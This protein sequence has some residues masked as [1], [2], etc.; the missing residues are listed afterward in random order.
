M[1]TTLADLVD[2]AEAIYRSRRSIGF[3]H[4]S[5]QIVAAEWARYNRGDADATGREINAAVAERVAT[6][7]GEFADDE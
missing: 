6:A 7:A 4:V 5:A 2:A 3:S 1:M